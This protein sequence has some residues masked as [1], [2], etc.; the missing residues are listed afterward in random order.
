MVQAS[1]LIGRSSEA[2]GVSALGPTT[3]KHG[4]NKWKDK[5]DQTIKAEKDYDVESLG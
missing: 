1:E 2:T 4:T 3:C 5:A